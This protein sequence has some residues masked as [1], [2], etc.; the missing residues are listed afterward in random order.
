MNRAAAGNTET[1]M[2]DDSV[3]LLGVPT[4]A[5]TQ[6]ND[7][8]GTAAADWLDRVHERMAEHGVGREWVP[9][10]ARWSTGENHD[11]RQG[12]ERFQLWA[13]REGVDFVG[14]AATAGGP[15]AVT[16]VIDQSR[17]SAD[18]WG[19]SLFF[20]RAEVRW[21]HPSVGGASLVESEVDTAD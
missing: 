3:G 5:R 19:P 14:T 7:I 13:T 15:I 16:L 17:R 12:A 2:N 1:I 8:S 18:D 6:Y 4:E 9:V 11:N 10:I 20:K 21:L